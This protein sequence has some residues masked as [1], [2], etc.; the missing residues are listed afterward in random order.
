MSEL[1]KKYQVLF[2]TLLVAVAGYFGWNLTQKDVPTTPPA[3]SA[4]AQ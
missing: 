2:W 4:P 3:A 1:W